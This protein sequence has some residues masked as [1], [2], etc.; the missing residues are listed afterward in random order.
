LQQDRRNRIESYLG[1]LFGYAFSL[2]GDREQARELVQECAVKAL[3]AAREPHDE[4]AYRAW[5]FRILRN[6]F[7]DGVRQPQINAVQI[8][9]LTSEIH[10]DLWHCD[11]SL[12]N[13]LTVRL[14]LVKLPPQHR[15]IVAL[16]DIVGFSYAETASF[17]DIPVGTVMSRISR[18]RQLLLMTL[19][20]GN[21]RALPVDKERTRS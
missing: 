17:L 21:V 16:I 4:P 5:L 3:G 19:M 18:A 2:C 13:V 20:Q 6:A 1:P 7:L 15:E 11:D 9:T 12:I 14:G 8:E 10:P